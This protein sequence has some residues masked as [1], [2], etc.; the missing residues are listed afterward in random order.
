M[1]IPVG[2]DELRVLVVEDHADSQEWLRVVLERHGY[3]VRVAADGATALALRDEQAP[4]LALVDVMLPD[5]HGVELFRELRDRQ[6]E[7][8]A[9]IMTAYGTISG[10]VDAIQAGA[11]NYVEKP[12]DPAVLLALL[13]KA[14]ERVR[15]AAENRRLRRQLDEGRT[16]FGEMLTSSPG[17]REVFELIKSVAPTDANVLIT[18]ENGTGKELV[19]NALH[20]HSRRADGPLVKINCAAIPADLIESELFGHKRGAFTG[21]ATDRVGLFEQARGGTL[22]LDEIGEMPAALQ[23]KLLRVL[24]ERTVRP[25][26]G[27]RTVDLDFRLVC[28]TNCDLQDAVRKGRFRE[29]LYFRINT[30]TLD[31]PPL[32]DRR[33]DVPLIAEACLARFRDQ[34]KRPVEGFSLEAFRAIVEY[35]WPGNVRELEHAV[36]RAVIVASGPEITPQDLP[37]VLTRPGTAGEGE[38]GPKFLTLAELERLTILRALERTGGNKRA[39]AALLGLYRPTLY[40]KLRKHGLFRAE[41]GDVL[42]GEAEEDLAEVGPEEGEDAVLDAPGLLDEEDGELEPEDAPAIDVAREVAHAEPDADGD[43]QPEPGSELVVGPDDRAAAQDE[44][45]HEAA[46]DPGERRD[47]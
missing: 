32:R 21:A 15:L 5:T 25:V 46:D 4:D 17:M 31:I 26:G 38:R 42:P 28:A 29:D 27:Q 33:E 45:H 2:A 43:L 47:G 24:Q 44:P 34:Y 22:L 35:A 30:V 39:A 9:V 7:L 14:G 1:G 12:V 6:P 3:A 8:E 19:A 40:S 41:T 23:P 11:F 10:A 18:G 37:E 20:A 13:E 36:E 16:V